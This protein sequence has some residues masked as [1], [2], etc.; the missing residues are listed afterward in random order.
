MALLG[1]APVL[2]V[3]GGVRVDPLE[4]RDQPGPADLGGAARREVP[5]QRLEGGDRVVAGPAEPLEQARHLVFAAS[6]A[7]RKLGMA[8]FDRGARGQDA[9]GRD[10][11]IDDPDRRLAIEARGKAV[12]AEPGPPGLLGALVGI[13]GSGQAQGGCLAPLLEQANPAE[14]LLASC[15]ERADHRAG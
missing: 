7:G 8:A 13:A 1:D 12:L 5:P 3:G 6:Q 14:A 4:R 10:G 9:P 11:A 2:L 15:A